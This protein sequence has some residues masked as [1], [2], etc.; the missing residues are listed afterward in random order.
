MDR[1]YNLI[2]INMPRKEAEDLV[3]E[4]ETS[5]RI[6]SLGLYNHQNEE[7]KRIPETAYSQDG[8][9]LKI[10]PRDVGVQNRD[11]L[12]LGAMTKE[13][14]SY[15]KFSKRAT[16]YLWES[17]FDYN[18]SEQSLLNIY[19][20]VNFSGKVCLVNST[21]MELDTNVLRI[22]YIA[23]MKSISLSRRGFSFVFSLSFDEIRFK[24]NKSKI[25]PMLS[26]VDYEMQNFIPVSDFA[27][28]DENG[29]FEVKGNIRLP[30]KILPG[31]YCIA[32]EV[33]KGVQ[34]YILNVYRLK[35]SLFDDIHPYTDDR[36]TTQN[37]DCELFWFDREGLIFKVN[38][39]SKK[40]TT[41]PLFGGYSFDKKLSEKDQA[42]CDASYQEFEKEWI[43][44][45][46]YQRF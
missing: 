15:F 26:L 4:I 13:G 43:L 9:S 39:V 40:K 42:K 7:Q 1:V 30:D 37:Y 23:T 2:E 18:T 44:R 6:L 24:P 38:G 25:R 34:K 20:Y 16:K 33:E 31:S 3:F 14:L 32:F 11:E 10:Q 22:P 46:S 36:F 8:S 35:K 12:I 45:S 5:E 29:V 41:L 28:R 19:A 27:I 17:Y 21:K